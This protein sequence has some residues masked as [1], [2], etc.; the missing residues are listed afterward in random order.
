MIAFAVL[1]GAPLTV[2]IKVKRHPRRA[3]E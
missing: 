1:V 3:A 2:L